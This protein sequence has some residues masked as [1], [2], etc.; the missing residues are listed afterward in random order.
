MGVSVVFIGDIDLCGRKLK[1]RINNT[2]RVADVALWH[3]PKAVFTKLTVQIR[4][5]NLKLA[6][7]QTSGEFVR[8][9]ESCVYR[10]IWTRP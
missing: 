3:H 6:Y 1:R 7:R 5:Y 10:L 8:L 4:L 9:C 2:L